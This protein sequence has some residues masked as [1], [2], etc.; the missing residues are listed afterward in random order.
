MVP[1]SRNEPTVPPSIPRD[2][3]IIS[4]DGQIRRCHCLGKCLCGATEVQKAIPKEGHIGGNDDV[5]LSRLA[6]QIVY[7]TSGDYGKFYIDRYPSS[8]YVNSQPCPNAHDAVL[9]YSIDPDLLPLDRRNFKEFQEKQHEDLKRKKSHDSTKQENAKTEELPRK[10]WRIFD[11]FSQKIKKS[12][13]AVVSQPNDINGLDTSMEIHSKESRIQ[14]RAISP[15]TVNVDSH[16]NNNQWEET[17]SRL[18]TGEGTASTSCTNDDCDAGDIKVFRSSLRKSLSGSALSGATVPNSNLWKKSSVDITINSSDVRH[19]TGS[20][21]TSSEGVKVLNN[22]SDIIAPVS[23]IKKDMFVSKKVMWEAW[24]PS[25]P[26]YTQSDFIAGM[27]ELRDK[28]KDLMMDRNISSGS[29]NSNLL[30][31]RPRTSG[32]IVSIPDS[33]TKRMINRPKSCLKRP[34]SAQ[35]EVLKV[36]DGDGS[37]STFNVESDQRIMTL[38]RREC[39]YVSIN[40]LNII[41]NQYSAASDVDRNH[42]HHHHHRQN[43]SIKKE[44]EGHQHATQSLLNYQ[45]ACPWTEKL[46]KPSRS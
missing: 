3:T 42:N 40:Q 35:V 43:Y 19:R 41:T 38:D 13:V 28:E 33:A 46:R 29:M 30:S 14:K 16:R 4:E 36:H 15:S 39:P 1:T 37:S 34:V 5:T 24:D 20:N 11:Y 9:E 27:N 12:Q 18:N 32:G 17:N 8:Y 2:S 22:S 44:E 10:S 23:L 25:M 31:A 6:H 7:Q 45:A 26:R 21:Q